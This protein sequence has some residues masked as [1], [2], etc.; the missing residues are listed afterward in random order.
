MGPP[1]FRAV[2]GAHDMTCK[3]AGAATVSAGDG[4][5]GGTPGMPDG[6]GT[7]DGE[8]A[9][10]IVKLSDLFSSVWVVE[11]EEEEGEEAA[12]AA[13]VD[14]RGADVDA[15]RQDTRAAEGRV[16]APDAAGE[17]A[18]AAAWQGLTSGGRLDAGA[19]RSAL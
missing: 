17:A 7:A 12:A 10:H 6:P 14:E 16:D 5:A 1:S 11:E 4:E 9:G 19:C 8:A 2:S 15:R 18:C 3:S 13:Q